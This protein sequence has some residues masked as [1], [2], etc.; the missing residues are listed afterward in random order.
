VAALAKS[1][2]GCAQRLPE[3][4]TE[5]RPVSASARP[6]EPREQAGEAGRRPEAISIDRMC[7]WVYVRGA[8]FAMLLGM[9]L[10]QFLARR[11]V[12]PAAAS[13]A[14]TVSGSGKP[15]AGGAR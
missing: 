8:V 3:L 1:R 6:V 2:T 15:A 11:G 5:L 10:E 13:A 12:P 4:E 9:G 7:C 14:S